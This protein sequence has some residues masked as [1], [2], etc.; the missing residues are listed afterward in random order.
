M[1]WPLLF[2]RIAEFAPGLDRLEQVQV[3]ASFGMIPEY[4]GKHGFYENIAFIECKWRNSVDRER[5]LQRLN[6]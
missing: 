3:F 5:E 4:D 1:N 2:R 6:A